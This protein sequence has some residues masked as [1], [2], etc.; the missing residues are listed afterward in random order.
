MRKEKLMNIKRCFWVHF[1]LVAIFLLYVGDLAASEKVNFEPVRAP[2]M[3]P[4]DARVV[5]YEIADFM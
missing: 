5:I 2:A 1:L 3:G 4:E